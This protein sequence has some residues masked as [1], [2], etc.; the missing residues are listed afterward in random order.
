MAKNDPAAES[1]S[2]AGP[3]ED[4]DLS[5]PRDTL[6]YIIAKAREFDVKTESSDPT[7]SAIDDDD[8]AVATIEDRP[9]DPV[10]EELDAII[11]DLSE[12]AQIDLVTLMWIGR[13]DGDQSDWDELRRVAI[14]NHNDATAAY[15]CGTPLLADYLRGGMAVLGMED[16]TDILVGHG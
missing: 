1:E 12:D 4:V 13:G 8:I 7:A 3:V 14:E 16:C 5:I 6:C 2:E 10:E 15:L 9:S 11:S